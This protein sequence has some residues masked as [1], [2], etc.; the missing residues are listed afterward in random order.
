MEFSV[1]LDTVAVLYNRQNINVENLKCPS[2]DY[3]E[4]L[5]S[6]RTNKSMFCCAPHNTK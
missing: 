3:L 4:A 1:A 5:F 6:E 2:I